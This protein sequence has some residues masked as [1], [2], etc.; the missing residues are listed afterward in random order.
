MGGQK[1]AGLTLTLVGGGLL[2]VA[3]LLRLHLVDEGVA[4]DLPHVLAA[5]EPAGVLVPGVVVSLPVPQTPVAEEALDAVVEAWPQNMCKG[6]NSASEYYSI[7][8]SLLP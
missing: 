2:H 7:A 6:V 4:P 5:R 3:F 1:V 8:Y